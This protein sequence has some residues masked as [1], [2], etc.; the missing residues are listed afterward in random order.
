MLLLLSDCLNFVGIL[1]GKS[2][3]SASILNMDNLNMTFLAGQT[4]FSCHL[5]FIVG[6]YF[7]PRNKN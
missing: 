6:V 3:V 1:L 5:H 2:Y 4:H 7:A